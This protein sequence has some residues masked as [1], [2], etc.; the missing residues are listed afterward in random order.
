MRDTA[1]NIKDLSGNSR[2]AINS[3]NTPLQKKHIFNSVKEYDQ[4]VNTYKNTSQN[5]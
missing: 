2:R 3:Q 4:N 1:N 5:R